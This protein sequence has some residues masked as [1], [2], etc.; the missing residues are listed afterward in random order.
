MKVFYSHLNDFVHE[1]LLMLKVAQCT[2]TEILDRLNGWLVVVAQDQLRG[3]DA[4]GNIQFI[5]SN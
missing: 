3:D 4:V 1:L 2:A 5:G